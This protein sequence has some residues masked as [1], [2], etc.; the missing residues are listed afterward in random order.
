MTQPVLPDTLEAAHDEIRRLDGLINN[1]YTAEFLEGVRREA[2]FQ[3]ET[4]G[5][6][7]DREKEPCEWLSL[8]VYL[9][10][11]ALSAL[12]AKDWSLAQH[13]TISSAAAL[14]QWWKVLEKEG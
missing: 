14:S 1:P 7:R 12:M 3:I 13:H 6:A 11:K 5:E 2:A 8:V 9:T 10:T 4:W